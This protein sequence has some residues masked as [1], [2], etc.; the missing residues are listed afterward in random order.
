MELI[1]GLYVQDH[2]RFCV[3]GADSVYIDM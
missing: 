1:E 2:S 3:F